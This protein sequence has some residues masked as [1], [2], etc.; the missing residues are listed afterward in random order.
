MPF[1]LLKTEPTIFPI[2]PSLSMTLAIHLA[3]FAMALATKLRS[4]KLQVKAEANM[5]P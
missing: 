1:I 5:P 2:K 4:L 3:P